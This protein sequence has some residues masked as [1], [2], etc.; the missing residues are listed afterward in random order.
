MFNLV[1]LL[2]EFPGRSEHGKIGTCQHQYRNIH[3]ALQRGK[4]NELIAPFDSQDPTLSLDI[5]LKTGA[6]KTEY[7]GPLAHGPAGS[8]FVYLVWGEVSDLGYL[9]FRRIKILLP[10]PPEV[11]QKTAR[12]TLTD[13][14]G[15]PICASLKPPFIEWL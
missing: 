11:G 2:T 3:L 15:D 7:I 1:L 5:P 9:P 13:K 12:I 4:E 8:K 6:E 10:Y 14:K